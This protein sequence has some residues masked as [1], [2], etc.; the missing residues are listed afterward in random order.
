MYVCRW[1]HTTGYE[2]KTN[3]ENLRQS[4]K[5]FCV[6][7]VDP[8]AVRQ[9]QADSVFEP[10]FSVGFATQNPLNLC[11]NK[12]ERSRQVRNIFSN[13]TTKTKSKW[14]QQ[15]LSKNN[16]GEATTKNRSS[17]NNESNETTTEERVAKKPKNNR[18]KQKQKQKNI[19]IVYLG[20][21]HRGSAAELGAHKI[22]N[23]KSSA[24]KHGGQTKCNALL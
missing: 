5:L 9:R 10:F 2:C 22:S 14:Q 6:N 7:C 18:E 13:K 15:I 1:R 8:Q 11:G 16:N 3:W 12:R 23:S 21:L 4:I 17:N 19:Q 20:Q 24:T